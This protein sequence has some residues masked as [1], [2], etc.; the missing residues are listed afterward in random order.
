[1]NL[2]VPSDLFGGS[3][4]VSPRQALALTVATRLVPVLRASLVAAAAGLGVEMA[5]RVAVT[6]ALAAVGRGVVEASVHSAAA[7]TR[8]IVTEYVVRERVRRVR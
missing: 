4:A 1:M 7:T 6:R 2:P 3:R 5:L 8:T